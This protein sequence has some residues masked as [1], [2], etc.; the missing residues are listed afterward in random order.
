MRIDNIHNFLAR[1]LTGGLLLMALAL[2]GPAASAD[3]IGRSL[4][5]P[6]FGRAGRSR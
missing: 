6:I 4:T 3:D 5:L 2:A 1:R